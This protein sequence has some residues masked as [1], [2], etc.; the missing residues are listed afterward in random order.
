MS[1]QRGAHDARQTVSWSLRQTNEPFFIFP[2][3]VQFHGFCHAARHLWQDNA[4][5][6]DGG[7]SHAP[8]QNA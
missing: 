1:E 5:F 7:S 6:A 2:F 4:R 8:P 3:L